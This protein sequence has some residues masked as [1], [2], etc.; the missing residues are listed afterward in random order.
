MDEIPLRGMKSRHWRAGMGGAFRSNLRTVHD[1]SCSK[2]NFRLA[3][4]GE[5]GYD[6]RVL[7]WVD[8]ILPTQNFIL[9]P[10]TY[11]ITSPEIAS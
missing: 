4:A 9:K 3:T 6:G 1:F 2:M 5:F 10:H 11:E 7:D 8:C